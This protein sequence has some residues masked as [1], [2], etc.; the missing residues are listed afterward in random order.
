MMKDKKNYFGNGISVGL[1]L[2]VVFGII[3]DNL[4]L[5]IAIGICLGSSV[6]TI[7][8]KKKTKDEYL[9]QLVELKNSVITCVKQNVKHPT[10]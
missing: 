2:G 1:C 7:V 3:L 6:G 9:F 10:E 5:G 4:A 8:Y